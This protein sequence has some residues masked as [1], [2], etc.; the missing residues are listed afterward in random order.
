[1]TCR[2]VVRDRALARIDRELPVEA[3]KRLEEGGGTPASS[4][5]APMI[6]RPT[7]RPNWSNPQGMLIAGH[8]VI[9]IPDVMTEPAM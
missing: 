3:G 6:W 2:S 5:G 7:G 1:M 9:E 4:C 8:A